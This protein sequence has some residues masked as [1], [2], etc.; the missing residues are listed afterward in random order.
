MLR[1]R[2]GLSPERIEGEVKA[3]ASEHALTHLWWGRLREAL[4]SNPDGYLA[5]KYRRGSGHSPY[6]LDIKHFTTREDAETRLADDPDEGNILIP[7]NELEWAKYSFDVWSSDAGTRL[8]L[9]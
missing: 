1:L 2:D 6:S 7:V 4:Y 8:R 9:F 5:C 3:Y